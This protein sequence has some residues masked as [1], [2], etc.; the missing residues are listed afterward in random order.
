MTLVG[1]VLV[2]MQLLVA[3]ASSWHH[4][5]EHGPSDHH[6]D[7]AVCVAVDMMGGTMLEAPAMAEAPGRVEILADRAQSLV[8]REE[9]VATARGPPVLG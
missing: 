1:V 4:H 6:R 9:V 8:S 5:D 3:G 2:A 7:C